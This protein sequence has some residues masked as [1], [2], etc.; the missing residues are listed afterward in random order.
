MGEPR[1][2]SLRF[3]VDLDLVTDGFVVGFLA[4]V[5]AGAGVVVVG[6]MGRLRFFD[7]LAG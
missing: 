7:L 3:L 4:G 2:R 1:P 6:D 5:S